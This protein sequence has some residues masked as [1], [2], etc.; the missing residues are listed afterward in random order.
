MSSK[1][2]LKSHGVV[3]GVSELLL[4]P[5]IPLRRLNRHV[6]Q[7]KLNLLQ[8]SPRYMTESCACSSEV[9]RSERLEFRL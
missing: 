6:S 5:E 3:H 7:E 4:R 9:V 8:F 1:F 2:R